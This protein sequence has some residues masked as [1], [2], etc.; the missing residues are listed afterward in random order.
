MVE[1]ALGLGERGRDRQHR[2]GNGNG[3]Y[4]ERARNDLGHIPYPLGY[5]DKQIR[6]EPG[7]ASRGRVIFLKLWRAGRAGTGQDR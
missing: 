2:N 7:H 1:L 4:D 5:S 6:V 3:K